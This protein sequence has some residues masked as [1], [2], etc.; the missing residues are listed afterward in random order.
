MNSRFI[1]IIFFTDEI[2][3]PNPIAMDACKHGFYG[4]TKAHANASDQIITITWLFP[5]IRLFYS[6]KCTQCQ[7]CHRDAPPL[8]V[9][10]PELKCNSVSFLFLFWNKWT[11]QQ[12][13]NTTPVDQHSV[14]ISLISLSTCSK[15]HLSLN[16]SW[17]GDSKGWQQNV[18]LSV[19]PP[20]SSHMYTWESFQ[21]A[22]GYF[23]NELC[24]AALSGRGILHGDQWG[25]AQR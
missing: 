23:N 12:V 3:S 5:V 6:C 10:G 17:R 25:G 7:W 2:Q 24:S 4:I 14:V 13:R 19:Q 20:Y 22:R 9:T 15:C 21:S 11:E 16:G 18:S 8:C 1:C